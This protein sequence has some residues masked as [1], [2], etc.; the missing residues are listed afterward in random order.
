M[1]PLGS[2]LLSIHSVLGF[3][4]QRVLEPGTY[5]PRSLLYPQLPH[6]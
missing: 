4:V 3:T 1:A 6:T 2:L 5:L